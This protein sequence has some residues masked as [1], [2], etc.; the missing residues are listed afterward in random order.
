MATTLD[1]TDYW[2]TL[3]APALFCFQAS[4]KATGSL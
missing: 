2:V 1:A 3:P 4:L